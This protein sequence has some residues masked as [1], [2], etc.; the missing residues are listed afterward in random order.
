MKKQH[1][2]PKAYKSFDPFLKY[3]FVLEY[4]KNGR[5]HMQKKNKQKR[6]AI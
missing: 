3:L 1:S 5:N 4:A 6:A 2:S